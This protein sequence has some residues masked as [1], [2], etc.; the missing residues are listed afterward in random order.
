MAPILLVAVCGRLYTPIL[1]HLPLTSVY[2]VKKEAFPLCRHVYSRF[3]R[4]CLD[5]IY[6]N[7]G[8]KV[9]IKW[10]RNKLQYNNKTPSNPSTMLIILLKN[11]Q[12][13]QVF[14]Y[15]FTKYTVEKLLL[16]FTCPD[17]FIWRNASNFDIIMAQNLQ[18][19]Q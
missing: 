11:N 6:I 8:I 18:M 9:N 16:T 19:Q 7:F 15:R 5:K 17:A 13:F 3:L 10:E 4:R 2:R 1:L 14:C 12:T